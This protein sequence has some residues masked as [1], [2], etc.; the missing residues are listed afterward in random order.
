MVGEILSGVGSLIGAGTGIYNSVQGNKLNREQ[1]EYSKNLQQQIF[2]REDT[3]VQRRVKDLEAAGMSKWLAAG[4]G[5][6]S[7][8]VV[9]TNLEHKNMDM[10]GAIQGITSLADMMYNMQQQKANIDLS[11]SQAK[12]LQ[13][14]V[15]TEAQ[16]R[17][18][19]IAESELTEAQKEKLLNENKELIYDLDFYHNRLNRPRDYN[20]GPVSVGGSKSIQ[21]GPL[22]FSVSGNASGSFQS[23]L[24]A[25]NSGHY[26]ASEAWKKVQELFKK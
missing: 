21:L 13:S 25:F 8:S 2:N 1:F 23:I 17:I 3:A 4:Q 22:G 20:A 26:T 19:M 12:L 9:G 10:S 18:N 5:A 7:G 6:G 11:N 24:D 15:L 14:Q 16:K